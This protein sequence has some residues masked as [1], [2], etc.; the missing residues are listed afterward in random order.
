MKIANILTTQKI[1]V[2]EEFNVAKSVSELI[3][4]LP[5][6]Y[7]GF[8]YVDKH[9]PDFDITDKCLG[10][11]KYWTFKRTEKRDYYEECLQWFINKAYNTYIERSVYIYIDPINY[12]GKTFRK[13]IRK[14]F[15]TKNII[16]YLIDDMV[17]MY[18]DNYI[19]GIN[20]NILRYM[21][22]DID[23]V[24]RKIKTISSV[25]LEGSDILIE[26]KKP[27][28]ILNNKL[29]YIPLLYSIRNGKNNTTSFIH[30][31]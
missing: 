11:D 15:L 28:S 8:D 24:K 22:V 18:G 9:F 2:P 20:L 27:I 26:Y 14:I 10:G 12:R 23:K 1:D 25:F 30:I 21:G 6:L 4:G 17:Y 31:P 7:V 19:F 3:D 29:K 5:T 13:I 16:T